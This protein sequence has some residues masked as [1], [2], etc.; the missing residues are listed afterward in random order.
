MR[1]AVGYVG[2]T[3]VA[4][5]KPGWE[6]PADGSS[7]T[8]NYL[9]TTHV[10]SGLYTQG[11][12]LQLALRQMYLQGGWAWPKY[13]SLEWGALYGNPD[14]GVGPLPALHIQ[15]PE[16]LPDSIVPDVDTTIAVRIDPV[17]DTLVA[18]SATLHYRMDGGTFQSTP[19][20]WLGDKLYEAV[21]PATGCEGVP[22]FYVSASGVASGVVTRPAGAPT[23]VY[24][25]AVGTFTSIFHDDFEQDRDWLVENLGATDGD[26]ER[27]VPVDDPAWPFDPHTDADGSGHCYLT[28]NR[29]G[30]SGVDSGSVRLTSPA[31]DMT[32]AEPSLR[33]AFFLYAE[34]HWGTDYLRVE[35]SSDDLAG[36]W[37]EV[38]RH[39]FNDGLN[40][41]TD[42]LTSVDLQALGIGLSD[43]MRVRYTA[44]EDGSGDVVEAGIDAFEVLSFGC[45][46]GAAGPAGRVPGDAFTPGTPL[47]VDKA[48]EGKIELEWGA[49]CL[50]TDGNY[51]VYEGVIGSFESHQ[52]VLC[53]TD[54]ATTATI[55][56]GDAG[57]YYLVVPLGLDREGSYGRDGSGNERPS[58]TAACLSQ[59]IGACP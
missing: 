42:S 7:Q 26:W 57:R 22:E 15:F 58:S 47:T 13:E 49:S 20:G 10:S 2:A 48:L 4:G 45:S 8:L 24:S 55:T 43:R 35:V 39:R 56:P 46:S 31:V 6:T 29:A 41:R 3:R 21:L 5:G 38:A 18:G 27:G 23:E 28:A 11:E 50:P 51:A 12:A 40:W 9:F 30:D 52:P 19:L 44:H 25:A 37:H 53:S 36:P 59:E 34:D 33:Y 16:G 32:V 1:A 17:L 14:L 54:G